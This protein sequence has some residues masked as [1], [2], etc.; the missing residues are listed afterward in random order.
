MTPKEEKHDGQPQWRPIE[1]APRDGTEILGYDEGFGRAIVWW[2]GQLNCWYN[3][4]GEPLEFWTPT[5]W[6]P[7]PDPPTDDDI[8][9][10]LKL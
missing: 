6:M 3:D 1:T 7:L 10:A 4:I 8:D 5:Q 9:L 2:G